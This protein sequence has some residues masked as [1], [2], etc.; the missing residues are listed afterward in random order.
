MLEAYFDESGKHTGSQA[1]VVAGFLSTDDRWRALEREWN[2]VL[3]P[4]GLEFFHMT[5]YENRQKV[6]AEWSPAKRR[7]VIK[8]LLGIMKRDLLMGFEAVVLTSEYESLDAD[9]KAILGSPYV[10]CAEWCT[11][12]V[13]EYLTK[14]NS[15]DRVAYF[16]EGGAYGASE[17]LLRNRSPKWREWHRVLALSFLD[18]KQPQIQAADIL[19]Y[20]ACKQALR[21][22]GIEKREPR[23]P[24]IVLVKGIAHDGDILHRDFLKSLAGSKRGGSP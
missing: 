13:S 6:Y 22:V 23:K 15:P 12:L 8:R 16:F 2:G 11:H 14:G 7:D 1:V 20:E 10:L 4:N 18:K 5:D 9:D 19:A 3:Q 17:L 21:T 24:A